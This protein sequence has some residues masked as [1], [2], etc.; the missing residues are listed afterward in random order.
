MMQSLPCLYP[1]N[2]NA[3]SRLGTAAE[4]GPLYIIITIITVFIIMIMIIMMIMIMIII[5]ITNNWG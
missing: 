4:C 3:W 5:I 2:V 1:L